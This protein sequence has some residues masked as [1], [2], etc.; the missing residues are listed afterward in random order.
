MNIQDIQLIYN[1]WSNG[2]QHYSEIAALLTRYGQS[3]GDLDF[4]VF[5]NETK[6]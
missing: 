4:S 2:A 5:P 3:P 1:Y 6:T